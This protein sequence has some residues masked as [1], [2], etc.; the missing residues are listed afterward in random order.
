MNLLKDDR[1]LK[2]DDVGIASAEALGLYRDLEERIEHPNLR[3]L[4]QTHTAAH[5]RL[6]ER[7]EDARRRRGEMPQGSDPERSHLDAAGAY[8]RAIV[9]PGETDV[10]FIESMLEA[11]ENVGERIA[12]ALALDLDTELAERLQALSDANAS[13]VAHLRDMSPRVEDAS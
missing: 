3:T 9:L 12:A 8:L 1:T 5:A 7:L 6:L 13:F 11:A 2:L 10:H 4:L